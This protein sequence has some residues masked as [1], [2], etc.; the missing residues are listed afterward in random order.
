MD[1]LF[2]MKKGVKARKKR[3]GGGG[4]GGGTGTYPDSHGYGVMDNTHQAAGTN[5]GLTH[6]S[7][8]L[9]MVADLNT[10]LQVAGTPANQSYAD[11]IATVINSETPISEAGGGPQMLAGELTVPNVNG[12][13]DVT[14]ALDVASYNSAGGS[15]AGSG[16]VCN[17]SVVVNPSSINILAHNSPVTLGGGSSIVRGTTRLD[18]AT[19]LLAIG[20]SHYIIVEYRI[21][22][23][24][25]S[26]VHTTGT[27]TPTAPAA[28]NGSMYLKINFT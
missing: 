12:L 11:Y 14:I 26:G 9:L 19:A 17:H 23:S 25:K 6:A 15:I 18:L 8:T 2:L 27:T 20:S 16:N 24:D 28:K 10:G 22:I 13:T 5:S 1:I 3:L 4:G 21:E 7:A